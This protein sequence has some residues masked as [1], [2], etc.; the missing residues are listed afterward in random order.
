MLLDV[1]KPKESRLSLL[2]NENIDAFQQLLQEHWHWFYNESIHDSV[3]LLL[4][5]DLGWEKA[6]KTISP[7]VG[8]VISPFRTSTFTQK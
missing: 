5:T 1:K 8:E 6:P 4:S 2:E 3:R 7:P